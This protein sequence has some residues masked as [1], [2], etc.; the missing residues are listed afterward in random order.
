MSNPK[1]RVGTQ[2]HHNYPISCDVVHSGP[3]GMSRRGLYFV[4]GAIVVVSGLVGT[5]IALV[6]LRLPF[7]KDWR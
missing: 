7:V 3:S 1:R 5:G 6:A 4:A 2:P